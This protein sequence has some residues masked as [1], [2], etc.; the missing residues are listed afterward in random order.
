MNSKNNV[1]SDDNNKEDSYDNKQSGFKTAINS[2]LKTRKFT[3]KF[4]QKYKSRNR[5]KYDL[6]GN[7]YIKG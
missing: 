7:V 1:V 5:N 6:N 3:K 4:T 2:I